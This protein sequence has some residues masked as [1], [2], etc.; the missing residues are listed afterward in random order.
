MRITS[1]TTLAVLSFIG[2]FCLFSPRIGSAGNQ[3]NLV[4]VSGGSFGVGATCEIY[5]PSQGVTTKCPFPAGSTVTQ[6]VGATFDY[7]NQSAQNVVLTLQRTSYTGAVSS[8]S[9]TLNG[10]NGQVE[11]WVAANITATNP[12]PYDY[13]SG[14]AL[15]IDSLTGMTF[16]WY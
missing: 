11:A 8:D 15:N 5:T 1:V 13:W 12:S 2:T 6:A 9:R 14:T 10:S 3:P 4:T 7:R 16:Y